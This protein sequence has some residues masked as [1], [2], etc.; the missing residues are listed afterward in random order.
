MGSTNSFDD[1]FKKVID[2]GKS[3][4]ERAIDYVRQQVAGLSEFE[5]D[6]FFLFLTL[7]QNVSQLTNSQLFSL[8]TAA[9]SLEEICRIEMRKRG[10]DLEALRAQA[11]AELPE[12]FRGI[13]EKGQKKRK[14]ELGETD[15]DEQ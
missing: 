13:V 7:E 9:D 2:S 6:T 1:L 10:M 4:D 3:L 5:Q 14:D 15:E 8:Q 12:E 11:D